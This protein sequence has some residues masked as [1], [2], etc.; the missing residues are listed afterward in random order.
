MK[1]Y[2]GV[3]MILYAILLI[4]FI[5]HGIP[6]GSIVWEETEELIMDA[7]TATWILLVYNILI[8]LVVLVVG[9]AVSCLKDNKIRAKWLFPISMFAF[10]FA[11][12]P[13]VK[14]ITIGG[15]IRVEI[16][17]YFSLLK[18]LNL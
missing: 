16:D 17:Y 5:T 12:V 10:I 14:V 11:L 15:F 9:I 7:G 3:Y 18:C 1:K 6:Y 2:I 8:A 13:I 4:M